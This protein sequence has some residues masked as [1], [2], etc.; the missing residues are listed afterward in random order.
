MPPRSSRGGGTMNNTI[1]VILVIAFIA[2]YWYSEQ[3]IDESI[4]ELEKTIEQVKFTFYYAPTEKTYGTAA[5]QEYLQ[6]RKWKE[7]LDKDFDCSKM[8]A[9]LEWK[10]ENEGY[11]T[12]IVGGDSPDGSGR[13]AWLLV[14]TIEG[15]YTPVEATARSIVD[16]SSPYFNNY[17]RYEFYFETIQEALSYNPTDYNWWN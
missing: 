6:S 2:F 8:S 17:F 5:L 12:F 4:S 1:T 3:R 13:H 7:G 16:Q 10:L 15:K 14:E 11:H 9:Y